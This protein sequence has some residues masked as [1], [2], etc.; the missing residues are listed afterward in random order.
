LK[1]NAVATFQV[2]LLSLISHRLPFPY[3]PPQML[4]P[5]IFFDRDNTL[6][7]SDGYLGDPDGV[8]LIPGA[9]DAI[10]RARASGFAI[11]TVSNQSGVARGMFSEDAV[12]AVD[13]R[14][15][16]MLRRE[17]P[18]AIIDRHEYCPYHPQA[19]L[20]QYRQES[21][22]RKPK[23]GMIRRAAAALGVDLSAS[24]MIG[25]APRDIDAGHAAGCHTI[26]VRDASITPSPAASEASHIEP[27]E[28]VSTL[29]EAMDIIE[30]TVTAGNSEATTKRD[31]ADLELSHRRL[32]LV[33]ALEE[34]SSNLSTATQTV[35]EEREIERPTLAVA[36]ASM[37]IRETPEPGRMPEP[38][39]VPVPIA[40]QEL[41]RA[42][43]ETAIN[44]A[45]K[46]T[47]FSMSKLAAGIIQSLTLAIIVGAFFYKNGTEPIPPL[48]L[49]IFGQLFTIALLIM[50][51]DS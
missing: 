49:G 4:K 30:A 40:A 7:I 8:Q 13:Q 5:A 37:T 34:E 26:L 19:L 23:P 36:H 33:G 50:G 27:N 3:N 44:S 48:L 39:A 45:E 2:L 17:N 47:A 42:R 25:D 15:D 38:E 35:E 46:K 9:A 41:A 18:D 29:A 28:I 11:I 14:M 43:I 22:L 12:Q 24:W 32:R 6:I 31:L 20:E 10:A 16:E 51:R 1:R 21:D